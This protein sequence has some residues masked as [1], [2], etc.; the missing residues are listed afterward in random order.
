MIKEFAAVA[1]F[2]ILATISP[3]PDFA[4]VSHFS[5]SGSK[6]KGIQAGF[7]VGL[8][9]TIHMV[10]CALGIGA[11]LMS[12]E[13]LFTF[14]RYIGAA[15]LF[16]LGIKIARSQD[17]WGPGKADHDVKRTYKNPFLTGL[18]TNLLNPKALIFTL[19]FFATV[20]PV[21]TTLSMRLYYAL[22]I[23]IIASVWFL[24]VATLLSSQ[25]FLE[26][27]GPKS[28]R[29]V[30]FV[31]GIMLLAVGGSVLWGGN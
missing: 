1:L 14:L 15:Y 20:V 16:Y 12:H 31:F 17:S 11:I 25:Q 30:N 10:Y 27:L 24:F 22:Q 9:A 3:G 5:F 13:L 19:S 18:A 21:E 8:G 26:K 4:V 6:K 29:I 2:Q 23:G 7:G 28:S